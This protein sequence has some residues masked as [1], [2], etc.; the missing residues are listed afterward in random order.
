M[1]CAAVRPINLAGP[2]NCLGP[3]P[4]YFMANPLGSAGNN[5]RMKQQFTMFVGW[6]ASS[7]EQVFVSLC[8]I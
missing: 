2:R 7:S 1:V 4:T 3:L 5:S 8:L 6:H